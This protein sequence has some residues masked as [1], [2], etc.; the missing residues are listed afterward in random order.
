MQTDTGLLNRRVPHSN[1]TGVGDEQIDNNLDIPVVRN[2]HTG[3][4]HS[5]IHLHVETDSSSLGAQ[6]GT[7]VDAHSNIQHSRNPGDL[8]IAHNNFEICEQ[9]DNICVWKLMFSF[10]QQFVL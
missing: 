3:R 7:T 8:A 2:T 9:V 4:T 10:Y 6:I 1:Q 5:Y